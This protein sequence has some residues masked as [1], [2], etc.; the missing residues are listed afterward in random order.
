MLKLRGE[1]VIMLQVV[2]GTRDKKEG[3]R[4][5]SIVF[6]GSTQVAVF[7]DQLS[8]CD[9]KKVQSLMDEAVQI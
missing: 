9:F 2:V 7:L 6:A 4:N 8:R 1:G 5:K 3:Y